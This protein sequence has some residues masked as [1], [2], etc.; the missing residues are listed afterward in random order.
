M[1]EFDAYGTLFKVG[2][3]QVE[4]AVIV[5]TG[6]SAST[7]DV[8]VTAAGMTGSGDT[9][10]VTIVTGDSAATL[11]AKVAAALNA[12]GDI[13]ALHR[14][15]SYGPNVVMTKLVAIANDTSMNIAYTGGGT[16]PDTSSNDTTAGV[17]VTTVAQVTNVSGPSL[18]LD[19][20]DV[21]TH[22]STGAWEETVGSIL[23]SGDLT[24]DIVYDPADNT[25]DGTET[26]GLVYRY[27]NKVRSAF[28]I[29]FP[30]TASTTWSF[31][32]EI[33]GFEPGAPVDGALTASVTVKPTGALI[34]V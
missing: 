22:D 16:T 24:I 21:T 17:V 28:S 34:L 25:Q 19:T 8:T 9:T 18:S 27:K 29:V 11:A 3:A 12:D 1:S 7:L 10:N 26:G 4:T 31:D 5:G 32:G 2:T 15:H 30:D 13:T 6:N 20:V 23:R 33:T 14:I